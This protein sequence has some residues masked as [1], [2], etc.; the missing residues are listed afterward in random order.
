MNAVVETRKLRRRASAL[1]AKLKKSKAEAKDA[2]A[3]A[4]NR[5]LQDNDQ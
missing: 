3:A 1:N 5:Y 4:T 2:A